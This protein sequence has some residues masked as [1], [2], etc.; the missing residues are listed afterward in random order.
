MT[1]GEKQALSLVSK[2]VQERLLADPDE[3]GYT[4]RSLVTEEPKAFME[5]LSSGE[6]FEQWA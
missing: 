3:H 1:E 2:E 5:A 6:L 4:P